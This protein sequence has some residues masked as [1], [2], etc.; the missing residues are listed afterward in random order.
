MSDE[1]K[2]YQPNWGAPK[3]HHHHHHSRSKERN[4]GLGG[5]LRMIDKQAYVGLV[6][7]LVA[8]LCFGVYTL[9]RIVAAELRAMPNDDPATEMS[10][11]ELRINTADEQDALLVSD[12][13]AQEMNVDTIKKQVQIETRPVYR[14]PRPDNEWYLTERDWKNIW[15][16]YR[17]W[18][19]MRQENEQ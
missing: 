6:I 13:L 9:L 14:P 11:D 5:A 8:V 16:N 10:V 17:L 12:S 18:R 15:Q 4:R 7:I 3:K 2:T 19:K 1:P